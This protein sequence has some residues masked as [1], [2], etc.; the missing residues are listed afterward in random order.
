LI[1]TKVIDDTANTRIVISGN[2]R[3]GYAGN[4]D[5]VATAGDHI[6]HTGI[7]NSE[8]GVLLIIQVKDVFLK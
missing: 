2:A 3:Q 4:I 6:F 7:F 8:K 5:H 1:E